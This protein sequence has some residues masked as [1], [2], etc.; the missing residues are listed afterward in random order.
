M[1]GRAVAGPWTGKALRWLPTEVTTWKRWR[2]ARPATTV[3]VP[4]E[5]IER[6][7][8]VHAAYERYRE[9]AVPKFPLGPVRVSAR[10]RKFDVLTIVVRD[11][12]ARGYPHRAL[13][14]GESED[15]D[16]RIT[17][18]GASV[19]VRDAEGRPVASMTAYWFAW[20]ALYEGGTVV[21]PE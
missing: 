8:E 2:E 3:L 11:G 18:T 16:L 6:Y 14:E 4:P 19:V 15:G 17:K 13:R 12:K 20:C 10:Y 1:T 21:E 5:P 7:D 9:E